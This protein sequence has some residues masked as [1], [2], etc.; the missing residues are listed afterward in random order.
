[1]AYQI[2][3]ALVIGCIE[4]NTLYWNKY[5]LTE[6]NYK[7]AK[8]LLQNS[9]Q[10]QN[11]SVNNSMFITINRAINPKNRPNQTCGYWL[12]TPSQQNFW[13]KLISSNKGNHKLAS[14][15][16]QKTSVNGATLVTVVS[17]ITQPCLSHVWVRESQIFFLFTYDLGYL[18]G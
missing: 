13:L 2:R 15:K 11:N 16:L 12:I 14:G 3:L 6:D 10:L 8:E 5:L 4:T 17:T 18:C 7:S 1:M 9:G